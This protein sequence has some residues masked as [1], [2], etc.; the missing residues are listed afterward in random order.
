ML[1]ELVYGLFIELL[2]MISM[3]LF[4]SGPIYKISYDYLTIRFI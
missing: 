2:I 3:L 4:T 1:G